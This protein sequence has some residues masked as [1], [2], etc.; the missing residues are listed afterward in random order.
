MTDPTMKPP[1]NRAHHRL[2]LAI[3]A[4][5]HLRDTVDAHQS[6]Q[7]DGPA[8]D[9][10]GTGKD[11]MVTGVAD[12]VRMA[13]YALDAACLQLGFALA[14]GDNDDAAALAMRYTEAGYQAVTVARNALRDHG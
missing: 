9:L 11:M 12:D 6:G 14:D 1:Y 5:Q 13:V 2:L 7:A 8:I 4:D 3:S 10:V